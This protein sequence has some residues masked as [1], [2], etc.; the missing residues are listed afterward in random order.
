MLPILCSGLYTEEEIESDKPVVDTDELTEEKLAEEV[1]ELVHYLT[2]HLHPAY[3]ALLFSINLVRT[4]FKYPSTHEIIILAL[5]YLCPNQ[6]L[7][8]QL[9]LH[10]AWCPDFNPFEPSV[11]PNNRLLKLEPLISTR[12]IYLTILNTE[13]RVISYKLVF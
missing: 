2:M 7:L 8:T 11:K 1:L 9:S 4:L 13:K 6:L 3:F 12:P 5:F 10:F